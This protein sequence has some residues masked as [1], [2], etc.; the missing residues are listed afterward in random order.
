MTPA[1]PSGNQRAALLPALACNPES[2]TFPAAMATPP[3]KDERDDTD[4]S[5][6]SD[7]SDADAEHGDESAGDAE[8][9]TKTPEQKNAAE[10]GGSATE[11][12]VG[13]K[14]GDSAAKKSDKG[15]AIGK[16]G[17][18]APSGRSPK[19]SAKRAARSPRPKIDPAQAAP[20]RPKGGSLTKSVLLFIVV[21]G[22]LAAGFALLGREQGGGGR[23]ANA[24]WKTGQTVDVEITL[25]K[26][27][28]EELMCAAPQEI[29]GRRCAQER[30]NKP[31]GTPSGA[32]DKKLLKPYTTTN[33]AELLAAGLWSDPALTTNLPPTRF[34]VK[35][36]FTV[37]GIIKAPSIRWA[38]DRPFY[39]SPS[40]WPAGAVTACTVIP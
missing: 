5:D 24:S 15:A 10:P 1:G 39:D 25:V 17:R 14:L 12:T 27:D 11:A 33:G 2:S 9:D 37:E 34:S 19:P 35:C 32:D 30:S 40:D 38:S 21:V 29:N 8:D 36:K 7:T 3:D 13:R 28:R 20:L 6:A 26:Q 4:S 22:G 23:A 16:P 18:T 31:W